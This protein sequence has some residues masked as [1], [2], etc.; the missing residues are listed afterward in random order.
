MNSNEN[1]LQTILKE[2]NKNL[3][4]QIFKNDMEKFEYY[5]K[6]V[7]QGLGFDVLMRVVREIFKYH[8]DK[9]TKKIKKLK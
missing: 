6:S 4:E 3:L 1:M 7:V 9:M 2:S 8:N 5:E